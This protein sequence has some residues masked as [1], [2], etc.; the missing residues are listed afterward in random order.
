MLKQ[1]S[2]PVIGQVP[3]SVFS[4]NNVKPF[5]AKKKRIWRVESKENKKAEKKRKQKGQKKFGT[6]Q[7]KNW[8]QHIEVVLDYCLAWIGW[9]APY[10]NLVICGQDIDLVLNNSLSLTRVLSS[11]WKGCYTRSAYWPCVW[12]FCLTHLGGHS[13]MKITLSEGGTLTS[14]W[15]ILSYFSGEFLMELMLSEASISTSCRLFCLFWEVSSLSNWYYPRS[16]FW[17]FA[18]LFCLNYFLL[19][20]LTYGTYV[21]WGQHIDLALDYSV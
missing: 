20:S 18:R 14:C 8:G 4:N 1:A 13:L 5:L 3:F 21:V 19:V 9:R 12:L 6:V 16:S 17:L 7:Q 15:N 2:T 11:L 10:G